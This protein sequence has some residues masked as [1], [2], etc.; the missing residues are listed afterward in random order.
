MPPD[1]A[2]ASHESE[3]ALPSASAASASAGPY[4]HAIEYATKK[5]V[6]NFTGIFNT[7]QGPPSPSPPQ[8]LSGPG[9]AFELGFFTAAA[10]ALRSSQSPLFP[11]SQ[12]QPGAAGG[13]QQRAGGVGAQQRVCSGF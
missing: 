11:A 4:K 1:F 2:G 10:A 8:F 3:V 7:R 5:K 12:Q 13:S 9:M 6:I